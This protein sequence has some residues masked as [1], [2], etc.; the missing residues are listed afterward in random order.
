MNAR[1]PA[2]AIPVKKRVGID[3]KIARAAVTPIN[4]SVIHA[5]ETQGFLQYKPRNQS[6]ITIQCALS[7]STV[8][9]GRRM[10]V[11]RFEIDDLIDACPLSGLQKY[12]LVLCSLA[13]LLDGYDLQVLALTVPALTKAWSITPASLSVAQS[14]A[15]L[16]MGLGAAFL[17]PLG[18]R[19]GRRTVLA[20]TLAIV[21]ASS[22]AAALA[23]DAPQL[24]ICRFFT[25]AAL[26]ASLAN[27]YTLTADFMPRRRR[28]GLITL[29]YCNTATGALVAGL[30]VPTVISHFG[31]PATFLIGGALPLALS[32]ALFATGPESIKFLLNRRPGSPAIAM[33]LGR[34]APGVAPETVYLKPA[35]QVLAGSVRDLMKRPY[36]APTLLLWL[37]FAM[38]SFNLYLLVSWLPTLLTGTGWLP[39]QAVHAMAFNQVGGILGGLSLATLMDRFGAERTLA[40]GFAVNAVALMLFLVVPSGFLSWGALRAGDRRLHRWFAV[41]D[42]IAGRIAVSIEHPR[43]RQ[44]LG[45]RRGPHRRFREPADRRCTDFRRDRPDPGDCG[46]RR[47]RGGLRYFD[48]GPV[49]GAAACLT[50]NFDAS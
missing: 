19:F 36:R 32:A 29:S 16:G 31:W 4:A 15:L 9:P 12:V 48:A 17:A 49:A 22:L 25:G 33:I 5:N 7:L 37:G 28:A 23:H 6:S 8:I 47:S 3:Q 10:S 30:V 2:A 18:D 38:N 26:G 11:T 14:A 44:W 21:G 35:A 13:V 39:A 1:P 27:A 45:L 43:D 24:T 34:I 20:A 40:L 42:R 41:R 46:S 50:G